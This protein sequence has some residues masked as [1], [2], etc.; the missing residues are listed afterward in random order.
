MK[1]GG[2]KS[3]EVEA[4][5]FA[6]LAVDMQVTVFVPRNESDEEMVLRRELMRA[7]RKAYES[8]LSSRFLKEMTSPPS[9]KSLRVDEML[10]LFESLGVKDT[11][12]NR[13]KYRLWEEL[14]PLDPLQRKCP[15][16]GERPRSCRKNAFVCGQCIDM[17]IAKRTPA[18][19]SQPHQ[20]RIPITRP[21]PSVMSCHS[22]V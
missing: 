8:K 20:G 10:G 12:R 9:A 3:L 16:S 13:K 11:D 18:V 4:R 21:H 6:Q 15:Y 17:L 19:S 5:W 1:G 22:K 2:F 7:V 14:N